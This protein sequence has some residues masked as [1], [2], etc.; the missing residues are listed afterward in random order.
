[1]NFAVVPLISCIISF[2]FAV[3]VLDQY[4]AR[5]KPYQLIWSIGLFMYFISTGA[6]FW[7]GTWGLNETVYRLWYLLGAT[8]VAAY[9][10]MGTIYLLVPRRTANIVMLI[11]LVASIY[12]V[13]RVFSAGIDISTLQRLSVTAMPDGVRIITPF[14]NTFGAVALVGGAIYSVWIFWRKRILAHRVASNIL[15]AVGAILPAFG[16]ILMRFWD[17]LTAFYLLELFGVAIIFIGFLRSREVFGFYRFPLVHGFK[18]VRGK[19]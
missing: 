16:G 15:I 14:F 12:A 13:V 9:L 3:T 7:A 8:F 1:M 2:V 10:G 18:M 4:F 19:L 11:L 17:S 6:E 5:R